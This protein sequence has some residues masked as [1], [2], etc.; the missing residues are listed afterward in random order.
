[1]SVWVGRWRS[2]CRVGGRRFS[3][4]VEAKR[5]ASPRSVHLRG[6][7]A[8]SGRGGL[9]ALW[10]NAKEVLRERNLGAVTEPVRMVSGFGRHPPPRSPARDGFLTPIRSPAAP[11]TST[12]TGASRKI[13]GKTACGS[14]RPGPTALR[15][16]CGRNGCHPPGR[17]SRA[18]AESR[19][20]PSAFRPDADSPAC[21][22]NPPGRHVRI[23]L[24]GRRRT[25]ATDANRCHTDANH[26]HSASV[27][28]QSAREALSSLPKP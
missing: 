7:L 21:R 4:S 27:A 18:G 15:Y 6:R 24:F 17:H 10:R 1:M 8:E 26:C 19:D 23:Q 13:G 22:L 9:P 12:S 2:R 16:L 20:T 5:D 28:D 25:P 11:E 14:M 3:G